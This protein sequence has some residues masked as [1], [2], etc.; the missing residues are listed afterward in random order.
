MKYL[1]M[2]INYIPLS[3][4]IIFVVTDGIT[5]IVA[6]LAFIVS[7]GGLLINEKIKRSKGID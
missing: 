2:L 7:A 4:F 5:S 3:S 6:A 1:K